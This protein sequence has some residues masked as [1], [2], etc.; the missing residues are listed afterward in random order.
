MSFDAVNEVIRQAGGDWVKLSKTT[1]PILVATLIDVKVQDKVFKGKK[2][3]NAKTGEVRQEW[4]FTLDVE[5]AVKKWAAGETAQYAIRGA[6]NDDL[7]LEKGGRL[8]VEVTED[9]VQGEKQATY[10][11]E[12]IPPKFVSLPDNTKDEDLPF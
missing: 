6:L 11:V 7:K 5:G 1:D 10:A 8:R 2:V 3:L 9:S 12:Y 4:L